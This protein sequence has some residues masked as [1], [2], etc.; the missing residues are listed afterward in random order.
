MLEIN[1][2]TLVSLIPVVILLFVVYMFFFVKRNSISRVLEGVGYFLLL[3]VIITFIVVGWGIA[4]S[5]I[6]QKQYIGLIIPL[7]WFYLCYQAIK[8]LL[9]VTF[10]I[11]IRKLIDL[12]NIIDNGHSILKV[13]PF[14]I[15]PLG[16]LYFTIIIFL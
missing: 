3:L 7:G 15:L 5:L 1:Q 13:L 16:F 8:A 11:S 12:R 6:E 4:G 14:S 2:E 9:S 10:G